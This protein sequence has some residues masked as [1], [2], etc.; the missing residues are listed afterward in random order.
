M[1]Y[2][3]ARGFGDNSS[4]KNEHTHKNLTVKIDINNCFMYTFS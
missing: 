1:F 3:K 2:I 4:E